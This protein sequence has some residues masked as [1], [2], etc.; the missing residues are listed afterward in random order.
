M[1]HFIVSTI[2]TRSK[3]EPSPASSDANGSDFDFS[4]WE[5]DWESVHPDSAAQCLAPLQSEDSLATLA[6]QDFV[7]G[8][9]QLSR[10]MC[11]VGRE[12]PQEER[13]EMLYGSDQITP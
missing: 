7:T 8:T 1:V 10:I 12:A 2:K 5:M 13:R 11:R 6:S 9:V 3:T 4:A